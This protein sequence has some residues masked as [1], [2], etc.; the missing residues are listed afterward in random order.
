MARKRVLL[1]LVAAL[2]VAGASVAVA[3]ASTGH[4]SH[5]RDGDPGFGRSGHTATPIKHVVVIFQENVSFD[6][7]FGTYPD[8]ANTDGQTFHA[9]PGTPAVDGLTP[10]DSHSLPP[11]LRHNKN[12]LTSNPNT[13]LPQRLDS[14]ATGSSG[15]AG[16]QLTC[17]QDHDYSDEQQ[18][19]D[20]GKMDH[21][22]QSVGT[23]GGTS[24][25]G[26]PCQA[27]QV[28]DYYDGNTVTA[29][30]NYAQH[31]S[32]DDNSF[33]T[34]FGPSSP[35]A[36]NL[37]SG[38]TGN[39]DTA[40]TAN[41]PSVSTPTS[42]DG[43][44]TPNGKGGFSLTSDAQPY[45]DDCST[46][47][48]VALSGTNIGDELNTAGLSWGWFQGGFDPTTTFAAASA[49][50]EIGHS[51]QPT[52]QFI[53]D[54]FSGSFTGKN[55]PPHASNEA[56]CDA[57]HPIGV[58]LGGTGQWGY[59]DDYIPH[60][61]PFDYYASTANP[62]HLAIPTDGAGQDT[63]AG[64]EEIGTD[65]QSYVNGLPQFNTPNHQYDTSD[66]DQLV[67]GIGDGEL[68][69]SALPNVSFLKAPGYEDGHPG[70][71]DPA[72]EQAFVAKEIDSLMRTPDWRSTV[73]IVNWDDSDGWYDHVY[74]GVTN[75]SLSPADNLTNTTFSG[76]SSGQCGPNPQSKAPLAGEQGRCGF[77]PRIPMLVVSPY[78]RVN[79]V[80]HDL[81]DQASIINFVE[82]NWHLPGIP[83]SADQVLSKLDRSEGLPFDLAGMFDFDHPRADRLILSPV[84]GE[85]APGRGHHHHGWE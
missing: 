81:T 63:F 57:V 78:A 35:G 10:A 58:A 53:P 3:Q 76:T 2:A 47:D 33:G 34:T 64:L 29:M 18:A 30:W 84:T 19:F 25:F 37:A 16:G 32:L 80:D 69:P 42:P 52:S 67:A 11:S 5:G 49:A 22:V 71:S 15:D 75:P 38:D 65:T 6:H 24:P 9:A 85:P 7:Y 26:A 54:E 46:R 45:W 73:V 70:Y 40:H 79:H 12:L 74:S 56:L 17:D 8:A 68:S 36:I 62:H 55:V 39:V 59:K 48:A 44:I 23:G 50:P 14:T 77:G 51:G 66:F 20:D 1:L 82:Y 83:G 13:A 61:E 72:D 28:M 31:F 60:H 4:R 43:D 27:A 41:N 21:F